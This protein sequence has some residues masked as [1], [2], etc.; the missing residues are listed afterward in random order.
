MLTDQ[1]AR[2][3][4]ATRTSGALLNAH[5]WGKSLLCVSFCFGMH[6]RVLHSR[7]RANN[8]SC[9]WSGRHTWSRA[10]R[11]QHFSIFSSVQNSRAAFLDSRCNPKVFIC[12]HHTSHL[13]P[14]SAPS[15]AR[16]GLFCIFL[17][18]PL[19][20]PPQLP[21]AYDNISKQASS[22]RRREAGI[23][24]RSRL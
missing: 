8:L 6:N 1:W 7:T 23:F 12:S 16:S 18:S 5:I 14:S 13:L 20:K 17:L 21:S 11:Q 19:I 2:N 24:A 9:D 15:Q 22:A 4:H 10:A 3:E